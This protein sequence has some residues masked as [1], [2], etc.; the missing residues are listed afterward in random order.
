MAESTRQLRVDIQALRGLA[1]AMVVLFHVKLGGLP[2]GYLGVDIFF[3]ISGYLITTLIAGA[4][5]RGEFSVKDFYLRRARRLLPAAYATFFVTALLAPWFLNQMELRDFGHQLAGALSFTGNIVLWQQTGYFEG[6]SDLKPLL[7]VWSLAVEEQYYFVL[8]AI[9]LLLRPKRWLRGVFLMMVASLALC[10]AIMFIKPVAAFYLLPTRAWEMLI[11]SLGAVL[12]L[13]SQSA[14]LRSIAVRTA[15]FLLVP[16]LLGLL[17]LPVHPLGGKHPGLDAFLVCWSTLVVILSNSVLV[18]QSWPARGLAKVGDISYSLYLVHWPVIAFTKNS[19]IGTS[20]HLPTSLSGLD[21]GLSLVLAWLLY[22]YVERPMRHYSSGRPSVTLFKVFAASAA[23]LLITPMIS[24]AVS[25]QIDFTDV[26]RINAGLSAACDYDGNFIP[27]TECSNHQTPSLLVWGDSF[28]MHLVPGIVESWAPGGI[29]QA[30]KSR[31]GPLLGIAPRANA[32]QGAG[33][34]GAD[35]WAKQ[36][37]EFNE[38]VLEYLRATASIETVVL[39]SP[40]S[41]YM[42]PSADTHLIKA[43][44]NYATSPATLEDTEAGLLRTIAAIHAAGKRVVLIAPPPSSGFNIGDCLERE[45]SGALVLGVQPGCSVSKV[46]YAKHRAGVLEVIQAVSVQGV[47]VISFDKILCD[48]DYCQTQRD[49]TMLYRD[50]THLSVDGSKLL[51]KSMNLG[52][53]IKDRA[54]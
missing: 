6:A 5:E 51:A 10:M 23:L 29:V 4:I 50:G 34:K 52:Q 44:G 21:L 31:C 41:Q 15:K 33:D 30:T 24:R 2:G 43:G 39:S 14:A 32:D 42:R 19:W 1:V 36:C 8:P 37:I 3:V 9:M 27:K 7:H 48:A 20:S 17:V 38:S 16:A 45:L 11:G 25:P 22:R 47:P 35:A 13:P 49:G 26:R 28:A 18:N 54:L 40:L 46:E 53:V 12:M